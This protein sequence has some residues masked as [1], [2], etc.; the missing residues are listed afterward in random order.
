MCLCSVY[1]VAQIFFVFFLFFFLVCVSIAY[2]HTYIP[3]FFSS[4][5]TLYVPAVAAALKVVVLA[6]FF[7]QLAPSQSLQTDLVLYVFIQQEAHGSH[8]FARP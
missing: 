4:K 8:T 6:F 7:I 1:I 2:Q 3:A 5:T